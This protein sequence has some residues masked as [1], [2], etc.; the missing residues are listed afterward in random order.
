MAK[1]K[2]SYFKICQNSNISDIK[3]IINLKSLN[4]AVYADMEGENWYDS[5][6]IKSVFKKI[7]LF[8]PQQ[9]ILY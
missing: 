6:Q 4:W 8:L 9:Q 3:F 2:K 7:F 5:W 1:G